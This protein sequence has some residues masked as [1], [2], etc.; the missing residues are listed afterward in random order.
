M[1]PLMR[2][3]SAIWQVG[4]LAVYRLLRQGLVSQLPITIFAFLGSFTKCGRIST[5]SYIFVQTILKF[6]ALFLAISRFL[7]ILSLFFLLSNFNLYYAS[8]FGCYGSQKLKTFK[9]KPSIYFNG[10]ISGK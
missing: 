3:V 2:S 9:F 8:S 7:F 4:K 6:S 10:K 5:M 1:R